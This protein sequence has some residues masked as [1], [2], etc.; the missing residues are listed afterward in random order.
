MMRAPG[1]QGSFVLERS[2]AALVI[3]TAGLTEED[4]G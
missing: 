3:V 4:T 1:L 2:H